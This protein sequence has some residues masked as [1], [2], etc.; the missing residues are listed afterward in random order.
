[1]NYFGSDSLICLSEATAVHH[2]TTLTL[3]I[4]SVI[5][6]KKKKSVITSYKTIQQALLW[7][8]YFVLKTYTDL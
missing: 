2:H 4:H 8:I 7:M 5:V 1:M 3:S 6:T